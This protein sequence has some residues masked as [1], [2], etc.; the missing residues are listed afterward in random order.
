MEFR[1]FTL[2]RKFKNLL[3]TLKKIPSPNNKHYKS[4]G[5]YGEYRGGNAGGDYEE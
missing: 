5:D 1:K 4:G 3:K 2:W